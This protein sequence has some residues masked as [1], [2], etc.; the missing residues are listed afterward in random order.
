VAQALRPYPQFTAV[1]TQWAPLGNTWYD[2][3][4]LKFNKRMSK[5][6]MLT[7]SYTWS[8]NLGTV[9]SDTGGSTQV[10]DVFNRKTLKSF[11]ANDYP[12]I[13]T[14]GGNYELP[15]QKI[16]GSHRIVQ[17]IAEG[18]QLGG[19][20]RYSSGQ[21]IRVPTANNNLS[22]HL[23]RSTF[24][25]RVAG[26]PLFLK[27]PNGPIDP[28]REL[29]LNP[30]AWV[31]PP[32]GQFGV[33]APYYTDYRWQRRPTE[34][35]SL[36]KVTR[37][38]EGM[39]LEVRAQFFNIFNRLNFLPMPSATNAKATTVRDANGVLSSG[40]GYIALSSIAAGQDRK[41]VDLPFPRTGQLIVRLR[42]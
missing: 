1:N 33:S 8:K 5:G 32:E 38:R 4:Q 34:Q 18:W 20:L 21:L 40:F 25:N 17:K 29:V 42:F 15:F 6:L 7:G 9:D 13:F 19:M 12:H 3:L 31:D 22:N 27:D 2:S 14:M 39:T 36:A 41:L 26:Q 11:T 35:A 30:A 10:N 37:I 23:N 16:A 24:A 28:L